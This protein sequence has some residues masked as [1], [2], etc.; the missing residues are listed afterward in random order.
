MTGLRSGERIR[1]AGIEIKKASLS[2]L[3]VPLRH[4]GRTV[5]EE[6]IVLQ[7]SV[8]AAVEW[9]G[10]FEAHSGFKSDLN[11]AVAV[12]RQM[13]PRNA[14]RLLTVQYAGMSAAAR[15]VSGDYYDFLDL[16]PD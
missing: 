5:I 7:A 13:Q 8:S 3:A 2:I 10:N 16:G 9:P 4:R 12:Q 14:K 6:A 11:L 1:I 15:G